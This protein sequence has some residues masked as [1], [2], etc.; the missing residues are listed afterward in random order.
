MS[1][2]VSLFIPRHCQNMSLL[3][4]AIGKAVY[5]LRI[6]GMSGGKSVCRRPKTDGGG[7]R[8]AYDES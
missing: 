3:Y 7:V 4:Q 2:F 5:T 8:A 1:Y 6:S